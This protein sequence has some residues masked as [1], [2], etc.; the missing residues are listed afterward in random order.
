MCVSLFLYS[1]GI[2]K[3]G[4]NTVRVSGSIPKVEDKLLHPVIPD[5]N[6]SFLLPFS[7][8]F[9]CRLFNRTRF[10]ANTHAVHSGAGRYFYLP[11]DAYRF[12]FRHTGNQ[13]RGSGGESP[14]TATASISRRYAPSRY[15]ARPISPSIHIPAPLQSSKTAV[16]SKDNMD[17]IKLHGVPK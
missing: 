15:V 10:T 16:R 9:P 1:S 8:L 13:T 3:L 5:G 4:I 6:L 17:A 11:L 2:L 14:T 12:V 7:S